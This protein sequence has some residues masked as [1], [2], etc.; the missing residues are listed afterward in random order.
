MLFSIEFL[1]L[2]RKRQ[3]VIEWTIK[4]AFFS[5]H[6]AN[7]KVVFD[8]KTQRGNVCS[9]ATAS[10]ES[11]LRN[12]EKRCWFLS[13]YCKQKNELIRLVLDSMSNRL[14]ISQNQFQ[15]HRFPNEFRVWLKK[16][17]HRNTCETNEQKQIEPLTA[18]Y[19]SIYF[20]VDNDGRTMSQSV[21]GSSSSFV[22]AEVMTIFSLLAALQRN[23]LRSHQPLPNLFT[24]VYHSECTVLCISQRHD[25]LIINSFIMH[26]T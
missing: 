10:G 3:K 13:V 16:K 23:C 19:I 25:T 5:P 20:H 2:H 6:A 7:G 15:T 18:W 11:S 21:I 26:N 17:N 24:C 22:Y 4:N 1:Q 8:K 14:T 12:D 9:S